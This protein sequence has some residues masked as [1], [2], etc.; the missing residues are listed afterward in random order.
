[1]LEGCFFSG[2]SRGRKTFEGRLSS[3]VGG[4]RG[5]AGAGNPRSKRQLACGALLCARKRSRFRNL[6]DFAFYL[7]ERARSSLSPVSDQLHVDVAARRVAIGADLLVR[8]F[9]QRL[10]YRLRQARVGHVEH[11]RQTEAA[12]LA[13][14]DGDGAFH[15]RFRSVLFVLLG[16]EVERAAEAGGVAGGEQV[17][18]RPGVRLAGPAHLLRHRQI[19]VTIPSSERVWPLRPPIAVPWAV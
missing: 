16:D 9:R 6:P 1:M 19:E 8:L 17:L 13:R 10:K 4:W 18:G 2:F 7:R 15:R 5:A 14:S 11:D 3:R 12:L